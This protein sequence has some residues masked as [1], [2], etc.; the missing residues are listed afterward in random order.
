[1]ANA[2]D[3]L[4]VLSMTAGCREAEGADQ[5]SLLRA[6]AFVLGMI[7]CILLSSAVT[8]AAGIISVSSFSLAK[9]LHVPSFAFLSNLNSQGIR[10]CLRL[11]LKHVGRYTWRKC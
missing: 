2:L 6:T 7:G 3:A 4:M 9:A 5:I 11:A 1:M 8:P 10:G